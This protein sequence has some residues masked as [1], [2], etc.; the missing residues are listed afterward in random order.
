MPNARP[1]LERPITISTLGDLAPDRHRLFG[2]CRDCGDLY[3]GTRVTTCLF[4]SP[5]TS[6]GKF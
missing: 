6:K 2:D 4:G 5:S 3:R 1:D